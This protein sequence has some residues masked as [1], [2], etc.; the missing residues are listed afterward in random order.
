MKSNLIKFNLKS[1]RE[2]ENLRS[3]EAAKIF[4]VSVTQIWRLERVP[5]IPKIYVWACE[6][7]S[8]ARRKQKENYARELKNE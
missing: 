5:L 7:F 6:G 8:A 2:S 3:A 1:W 4:G